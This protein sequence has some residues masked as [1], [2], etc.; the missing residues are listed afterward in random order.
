MYFF[1]DIIQDAVT[2]TLCRKETLHFWFLS[3]GQCQLVDCGMSTI[4]FDFLLLLGLQ[5]VA[6]CCILFL[7]AK[8][9]PSC[10]VKE[11]N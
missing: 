2:I 6:I 1:Y 11:T 5:F 3:H 4:A 10:H 7:L 9:R 8:L